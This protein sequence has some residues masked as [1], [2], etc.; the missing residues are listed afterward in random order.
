MNIL[1]WSRE[2]TARLAVHGNK[3]TLSIPL[4][5]VVNW[6]TYSINHWS[7]SLELHGTMEANKSIS[8]DKADGKYYSDI[9]HSP[10]GASKGEKETRSEAQTKALA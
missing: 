8:I 4:D 6:K 1:R 2:M 5:Q 10:C 9:T 7:R 3:A